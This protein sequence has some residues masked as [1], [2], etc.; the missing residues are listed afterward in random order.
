[1][2]SAIS[3]HT[4]TLGVAD[5]KVCPAPPLLAS[6]TARKRWAQE[7]DDVCLGG[8]RAVDSRAA[9]VVSFVGCVVVL[10][11]CVMTISDPRPPSSSIHPNA[12]L[13]RPGQVFRRTDAECAGLC[14]NRTEP[15]RH[16]QGHAHSECDRVCTRAVMTSGGDL[17]FSLPIADYPFSQSIDRTTA[18]WFNLSWRCG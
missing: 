12:G 4:V 7:R 9:T 14:S 18:G 1:M 16:G 13:G 17:P 8:G 10:A 6:E 3:V 15:A 2:K 5:N 11:A